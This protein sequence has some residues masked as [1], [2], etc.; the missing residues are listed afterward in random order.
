MPI[1]YST[2][3]KVKTNWVCLCIILDLYSRKVIGWRVSKHMSTHLVTATFKTTDRS[4]S[5]VRCKAIFLCNGQAT[6]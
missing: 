2:E 4:V 6:G 5:T 1:T 3:L